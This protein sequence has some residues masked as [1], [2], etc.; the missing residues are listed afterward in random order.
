MKKLRI[1]LDFLY[2]RVPQKRNHDAPVYKSHPTS[3]KKVF[4]F[5]NFNF[6][7]HR[8]GSVIYSKEQYCKDNQLK[9]FKG[10]KYN[11]NS[12]TSVSH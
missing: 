3:E 12:I 9:K 5:Q 7:M 1:S 2:S 10:H 8:F 4:Y 6:K 11:L